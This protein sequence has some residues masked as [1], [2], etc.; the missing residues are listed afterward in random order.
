MAE[1]LVEGGYGT[2]DSHSA[3]GFRGRN[4]EKLKFK[5]KS[6]ISALF[7]SENLKV[8]YDLHSNGSPDYTA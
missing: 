2:L 4:L 8:A 6:S 1:G 5:I 3:A 7:G